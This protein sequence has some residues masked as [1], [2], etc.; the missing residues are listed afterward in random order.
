MGVYDV[1]ETTTGDDD[2]EEVDTGCF[3]GIPDYDES[4]LERNSGYASDGYPIES[5][6]FI[7][8]KVGQL[9]LLTKANLNTGRSVATGSMLSG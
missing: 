6:S 7:H 4:I 8:T 3:L 1:S 2:I 9:Q 5:E